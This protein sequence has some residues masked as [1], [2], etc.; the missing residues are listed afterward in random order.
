MNNLSNKNT[1]EY[2]LVVWGAT[3]FTGQLVCEYLNDRLKGTNFNWA[4]AGRNLSKLEKVKETFELTDDVDILIADAFK[5]EQ[6]ESFVKKTRVV[7]S[8]AGPYALYG[9]NI[10]AACVKYGVNYVDLTGEY[11]FMRDMIEKYHD[12]AIANGCLIIHACGYDSIPF[13]MGV[14]RAHQ[15]ATKR[16]KRLREVKIILKKGIGGVSGGTIAS[17]MN[18]FSLTSEEK[19]KIEDPECLVPEDRKLNNVHIDKL[20]RYDRDVQSWTVPSIMEAI[21]ARVIYRTNAFLKYNE[22]RFIY[23]ERQQ[24]GIIVAF[25]AFA[26][27]VIFMLLIR[28][29]IFRSILRKFLPSPGQGPD[30][31]TRD[32]G[33]AKFIVIG[34]PEDDTE[35]IIIEGSIKGDPGYSATSRMISESALCILENKNLPAKGGVITPA[36]A[37]GEAI[38]P[39]LEQCSALKLKL[40]E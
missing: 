16:G 13:D 1:R 18:L 31:E 39:M 15:E 20:I 12:D 10:V 5:V 38:F 3:G 32:S 25:M 22:E 35:P 2:D 30:K 36:M 6:V 17:M 27:M 8:M 28:F 23:K 11:N 9:A 21:N 37:F 33:Y 7:I 34:Q 29:R 24:Y 40:K 4:I 26:I 19:V 14:Y